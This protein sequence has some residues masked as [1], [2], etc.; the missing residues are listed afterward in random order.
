MADTSILNVISA[1]VEREYTFFS[2]F[3]TKEGDR[4]RMDCEPRKPTE[5]NHGKK[6]ENRPS[7]ETP[8][9]HV[10]T[11]RPPFEKGLGHAD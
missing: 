9:P 11:T 5:H 2:Q 8:L 3:G 1:P 10:Q 6:E 4:F 7:Q